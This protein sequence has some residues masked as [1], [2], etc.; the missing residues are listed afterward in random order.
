[1][2][3]P[4]ENL[5]RRRIDLLSGEEAALRDRLSRIDEEVSELMA[6]E[7]VWLRL[8]DMEHQ[9]PESLPADVASIVDHRRPR[10]P[11]GIPTMPEMI[12]FTLKEGEP[13][14]GG[15]EPKELTEHIS[16]KWYPGV[17]TEL[18]GPIA[19]RMFKRG[20]LSK[21]GPRYMLPQMN[22]TAGS[23][24]ESGPAASVPKPGAQGREAGP[25]GGT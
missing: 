20:E 2:T 15:M 3:G 1:M 19:W 10:K 6:A 7:K 12:R 25:G 8:Q 21:D 13:L 11:E 14:F 4:S 24:Q 17:T 18:V 9:P 22:E 23:P 5:F 16:R